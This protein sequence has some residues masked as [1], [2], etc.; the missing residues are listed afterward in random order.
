[1]MLLVGL[2][3]SLRDFNSDHITIAIE[4]NLLLHLYA[5]YAFL[6]N[7]IDKCCYMIQLQK[8]NKG[9]I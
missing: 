2:V 3:T 8:E 5:T 9:N 6:V 1:M 7:D 4:Y